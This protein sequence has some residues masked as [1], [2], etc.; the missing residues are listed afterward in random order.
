MSTHTKTPAE[1]WPMDCIENGCDHGGGEYLENCPSEV[2]DICKECS[3]ASWAEY[4]GGVVLWS[5]HDEHLADLA[6]REEENQ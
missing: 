5:K 6:Q 4:E 2:V 1:V 3:D